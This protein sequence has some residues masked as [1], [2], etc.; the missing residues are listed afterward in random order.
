M[1]V[2][3]CVLNLRVQTDPAQIFLRSELAAKSPA[4]FLSDRGEA[5]D[6]KLLFYVLRYLAIEII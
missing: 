3:M 1:C 5:P 2:R 4:D 6:L